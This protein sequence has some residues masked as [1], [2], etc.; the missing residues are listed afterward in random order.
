MTSEDVSRLAAAVAQQQVEIEALRA[1]QA[2]DKLVAWACG[3]LVEQLACTPT[4]AAQQLSQLAKQ[5][6][7]RP[8]ELAADLVDQAAGAPVADR[9]TVQLPAAEAT[10]STAGSG[11]AIADAVLEEV[12]RGTNAAGAILWRLSPEGTLELVGQAGLTSGEASRWQHVPG[13]MINTLC[14]QVAR[15]REPIWL[16]SAGEAADGVAL[17][18]GWLGGRAV[19][20][21]LGP[22]TVLGVLEVCWPAPIK[23]FPASLRKHLSTLAD[24]CARTLDLR[25]GDPTLHT[26]PDGWPYAV[27]DGV[28]DS[29][30]F[31]RPA[32]TDTDGTAI[33]D[34]EVSHVTE[35]FAD[36]AGRPSTQLVGRRLTALY[37]GL[38]TQPLF[39]HL[40]TVLR[41]GVPYQLDHLPMTALAPGSG[42]PRVVNLRVARFVDGL[43]VSWRP[44]DTTDRLA[45]VLANVQ[46]LG[47]IGGWEYTPVDGRTTWTDY[48]YALFDLA[49][50]TAAPSPEELRTQVHPDDVPYLSAFLDLLLQQKQSASTNL[51]FLRDD[52]T[53]RQIRASAEP[54][55]TATGELTLVRGTFQDISQHYHTQIALS[56]T[57]DQLATTEDQVQEQLRIALQLQRAILPP[58]D[59]PLRLDGLEAVMRYRPPVDEHNVGGDWYDAA[60]LPGDQVL[61]AVGDVS[62]HGITASTTMVALRNGLR[63]LAITGAGPGR[64]LALLNTMLIGLYAGTT[65][66]IVCGLYAPATRT[67]RW[68]KAGHLPPML[69]RDGIATLL[70]QPRGILLGASDAAD[71]EEST[72][73]LEVGDTLV[74]YTDG[75][76]ERRGVVL[77]ESLADLVRTASKP[78]PSVGDLV[79]TLMTA[80]IGDTT[81]DTCILALQAHPRE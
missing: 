77:D 71:Y 29:G 51:R 12:S 61:F 33:T 58:A 4:E 32:Y 24:V 43:L 27:L 2:A 72:L 23:D 25:S 50:G 75:L 38:V 54:V 17:T 30:L 10:V 42:S 31:V 8:E 7:V 73:V 81:D 35:R 34:F 36:P 74:L 65:A 46:R 66:T 6:G 37:P 39:D 14:Q 64:L 5:A 78:V 28:L 62:G 76:I 20:P 60:E 3:V 47:R 48:T 18:G 79:D 19:L 67:L 15:R 49:P 56:A 11:A 16:R 13:P 80:Q 45:D 59:R 44:H 57:Q 21:L 22:T 69:V 1:A 70:R 40:Q 53:L 26:D 55:L 68:A 9:L 41:T 52:G 63:G